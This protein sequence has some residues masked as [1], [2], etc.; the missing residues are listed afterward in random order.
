MSQISTD[1]NV[2]SI[3]VGGRSVGVRL[4]DIMEIVEPLPA[5]KVP[6]TDPLFIGLIT[7]RNTIL[8]LVDL[9]ALLQA[10]D[11]SLRKR[12]D[13]KY[14]ICS[15][16][17]RMIALD[18]DAVG[19]FNKATRTLPIEKENSL[20]RFAVPAEGTDLPV[21]DIGGIIALV[22]AQ[23]QIRRERAGY[24]PGRSYRGSTTTSLS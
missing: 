8:P 12:E 20:I 24:A 17:D 1:H 2:L 14:V 5:V 9:R 15:D 10:G 7:L 3:A 18:V 21:L 13:E 22:S 16:A 6:L 19:D 11:R 23:N 4:D